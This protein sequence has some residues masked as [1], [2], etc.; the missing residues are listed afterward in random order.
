MNEMIRVTAVM[1]IEEENKNDLLQAFLENY[2]TGNEMV[3]KENHAVITGKFVKQPDG[4]PR[5]IEI[6]IKNSK[7]NTLVIS[8]KLEIKDVIGDILGKGPV[9]QRKEMEVEKTKQ[10]QTS[11]NEEEE[12]KQNQTSKNEEE[13]SKQN[14]T[15]KNEEE[16]SKQNQT[17][18]N[19]EEESK[20]KE[21]DFSLQLE[22]IA[23]KATNIE[24]FLKNVSDMFDFGKFRDQF[25]EILGFAMN[26]KPD[27]K[28]KWKNIEQY[29]SQKNKTF[30][31]Y[32]RIYI[33][34]KVKE[35][36]GK[37]L[38]DS[39]IKISSYKNY[40]F[41][42][43]DVEQYINNVLHEMEIEK[44]KGSEE[45]KEYIAKMLC[46]AVQEEKGD[47]RIWCEKAGIPEKDQLEVKVATA[48]LFNDKMKV[49][50]VD[51]MST[52]GIVLELKDGLKNNK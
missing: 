43:P 40:Q 8:E 11:Q 42:K 45:I 37:P 24:D 35:V 17:S 41:R 3:I 26:R 5:I 52:E 13:E 27:E 15:S 18:K 46:V 48:S 23:Q 32:N 33:G 50:G 36:T 20:Q 51:Q 4:I 7:I 47:Y 14:Q 39:L 12:S 10:N 49:P 21:K 29:M 1:E 44:A 38:L 6:I 28:I 25:E 22:A 16:E 31:D 19:E 30:T 2:Q 34:G 9:L